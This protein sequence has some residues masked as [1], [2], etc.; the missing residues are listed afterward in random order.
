M[1]YKFKNRASLYICV[2]LPISIFTGRLI[3]CLL[4]RN[5]VFFSPTDGSFLGIQELFRLTTGGIS[6]Y[7]CLIGSLLACHLLSKIEKVS[8]LTAL[9]LISPGLSLL[10]AFFHYAN[11]LGGEGFGNIADGNANPVFYVYND[12]GEAYLAVFRFEALFCLFFAIYL[13]F[14]QKSDSK[15]AL[16]FLSLYAAIFLFFASLHRDSSLRLESNGFIRADQLM[17][18]IILL[19]VLIYLMRTKKEHRPAY[20]ISFVLCTIFVAAAEF[21]EKIPLPTWLLYSLSLISC[22]NLG[23]V[24]SKE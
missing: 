11:F 3:Y 24:F 14:S 1:L 22:V 2:I 16:N 4:R 6:I 19:F 7:G 9:G 5:T 8:F 20:I 21:Y 15:K 18:Y 23:L 13:F 12:Y 17:S 10:M